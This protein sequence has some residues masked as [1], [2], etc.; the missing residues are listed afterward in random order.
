MT[1]VSIKGRVG[2][3]TLADG[4]EAK[5]RQ[6]RNAEGVFTELHGKFYEQTFRG[7]VYSG[8]VGLTAINAATYTTATTGATA[9]PIAGV[10]N[11]PNNSVN[12]VIISASLAVV[13]TAVAAT[14][15]GPYAW[16]TTN[17]SGPISTGTVPLN[18]KTLSRAGSAAR[19]MSNVALTGMTGALAVAFG[20]GLFGGSAENV[21]FTATAVAMQTQQ[22]GATELFDGSLIVPPGAVLALMATT[23]PAAHSVTSSIVWEEVPV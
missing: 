23:T 4:A 22:L 20:S 15:G 11:P 14:G 3:D 13:M 8:G 9:T 17:A 10:W 19:D 7:N 6:G 1:E 2:P 12:L 5:L 16:M 18:R 21:T